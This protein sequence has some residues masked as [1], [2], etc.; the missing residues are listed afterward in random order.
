[1]RTRMI[2]S[3]AVLAALI[4]RASVV[5]DLACDSCPRIYAPLLEYDAGSLVR[6]VLL[7]S[8]QATSISWL[9]VPEPD[10]MQRAT[11]PPHI[12]E[13]VLPPGRYQVI[14]IVMYSGADGSPRLYVGSVIVVVRSRD[15]PPP[16]QPTPPPKPEPP[17]PPEPQWKRDTWN[18]IGRIRFGS[19]GCSATHIRVDGQRA[20][21]FL[22]AA[23]CV[24]GTGQ[25]G[26]FVSR[27]GQVTLRV[28]VIGTDRSS[29]CAWLI[30]DDG[31]LHTEL[32]YAVLADRHPEPREAVWHGGFGIDKPGNR[33]VGVYLREQTRNRQLVYHLSV[34]SGD[35]GGAIVWTAMDTVLS[36]V[37]CTTD[38]GRA[39]EVAGASPLAC[40]QLLDQLT[41]QWRTP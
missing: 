19:S 6:V 9:V 21:L 4:V 17:K 39:G 37:C 41:S 15:P 32:P 12:F 33:E 35:S 34:S 22:T 13:A 30:A 31:R 10:S 8:E 26:E 3:V 25:I 40:R 14:V 38:L 23:H 7:G 28:R 11:T 2:W 24:S 20:S 36:P 18:A 5:A 27:D 16:P 29:D 1:M